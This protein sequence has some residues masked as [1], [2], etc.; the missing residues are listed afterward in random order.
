MWLHYWRSFWGTCLTPCYHENSTGP[1]CTLT[2]WA[3]NYRNRHSQIIYIITQE[4]GYTIK[5][6]YPTHFSLLYQVMNYAHLTRCFVFVWQC[7]GGQ[8]SWYTSSSCCTC[9][10]PVIVTPCWGSWRFF[11]QYRR[12]QTAPLGQ[13]SRRYG[14]GFAMAS[15]PRH[16]IRAFVMYKNDRDVYLIHMSG[17]AI[18]FNVLEWVVNFFI[19]VCSF[20]SV[21]SEYQSWS[22]LHTALWKQN[23]WQCTD[24]LDTA[25][26]I[27]IYIYICV[28]VC[29]CVCDPLC[30]TPAKVNFLWFA[31]FYKKSSFTW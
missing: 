6:Y 28:C 4:S 17:W 25:L 27:Y 12:T 8:I 21:I 20:F 22:L 13:I 2:V 7:W 1:F 11:I 16:F 18:S 19:K 30:E 26:S 24:K 31:V 5:L 23:L 14:L 15:S 29:V 10:R 9:C 3:Y